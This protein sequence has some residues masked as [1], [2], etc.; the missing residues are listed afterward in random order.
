MWVRR[1]V[2][3]ALNREWRERQEEQARRLREQG[4][5]PVSIPG[6]E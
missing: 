5:E 3:A 6:L 2:Q 1:E 4:L